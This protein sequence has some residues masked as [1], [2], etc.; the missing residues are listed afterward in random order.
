MD[1]ALIIWRSVRLA[2]VVERNGV[3]PDVLVALSLFLRV[4][5]PVDCVPVKVDGHIVLEGG[6][7]RGAWISGRSLDGNGGASR[8]SAVVEPELPAARPLARDAIE[9]KTLRA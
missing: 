4:V 7:D 9:L 6:P 1:V 3:G 2:A 5:T 8:A